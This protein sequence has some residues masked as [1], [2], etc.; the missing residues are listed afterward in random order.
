MY[1]LEEVRYLQLL[2]ART[3]SKHTRH[4]KYWTSIQSIG[5][6]ETG[7]YYKPMAAGIGPHVSR[8]CIA[9]RRKKK[10][11]QPS[12]LIDPSQ[13]PDTLT[14]PRQNEGPIYRAWFIHVICSSPT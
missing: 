6:M 5:Y 7:N 2:K 4:W 8:Q 11:L 14:I 3:A 10:T 9:H 1:V 13:G 12:Q